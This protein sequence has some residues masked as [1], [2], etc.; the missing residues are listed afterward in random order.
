MVY[1]LDEYEADLCPGCGQPLSE[2]L[3]VDGKP[4]PKYT[5]SYAVCAG[6]VVKERGQAKQEKE[7]AVREKSGGTVWRNA[8]RWLLRR[9]G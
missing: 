1:A 8:R 9:L 2:S 4:D 6:C 7:D 5:Y 3:H